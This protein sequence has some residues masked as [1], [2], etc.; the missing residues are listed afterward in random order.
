MNLLGWLLGSAMAATPC[1][2]TS[3]AH[4]VA[5]VEL[6]TSQGCSSCPPA[7][8]WLSQLQ[9][10]D[11]LV[12][13]ALHVRYWDYIGW[14]DPFGKAEFT[15][16]QRALSAAN[17]SRGVY[18]PGVFL[19]GR[20]WPH[21]R[22]A[23]AWQAGLAAVRA[24]PAAARI[25][26]GARRGPGVVEVEASTLAPGRPGA[27]LLLALTQGGQQTR[28]T[29]GENRGETLSNEH[30]AREWSGP[31]PLGRL[32]HR[33]TLPPGPDKPLTLVALVQDGPEILQALALPLARCTS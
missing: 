11:S 17:G 4:T 16:R 15:E 12:P 7:D 3:P 1:T 6:Y 23:R 24:R 5:V 28:V 33:L 8:R 20:E 18:T 31:L 26:L 22:D 14:K 10:T 13:L 27:R 29:A 30:V 32:N 2:A 9:A 21:W 25:E 19:Q